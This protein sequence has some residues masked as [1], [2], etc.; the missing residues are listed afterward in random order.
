M[1]NIDDFRTNLIKLI[2]ETF[3]RYEH[4]EDVSPDALKACDDLFLEA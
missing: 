2:N 4:G 3:D 1:P